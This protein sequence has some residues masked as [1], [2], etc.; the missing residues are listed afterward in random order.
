MRTLVIVLRLWLRGMLLWR[1]KMDDGM[2]DL[3]VYVLISCK[4]EVEIQR[5]LWPV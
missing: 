4:F 3:F 5:I 1:E 2:F